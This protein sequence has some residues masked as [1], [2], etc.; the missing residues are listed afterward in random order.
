M[1]AFQGKA[2]VKKN[3]KGGAAM[4][5]T[6]PLK[7][8]SGA[9]FNELFQRAVS[10]L[11]VDKKARD[12]GVKNQPP[13]DQ[14][15]PD[16]NERE[17]VGYFTQR[18]REQRNQCEAALSKHALDR[19]A[20]TSKVDVSQTRSSL[21]SIYNAIEPDLAQKEQIHKPILEQAKRLEETSLRY[22]RHFQQEH[23]LQ[24][25][26]PDPYPDPVWHFSLVAAFAVVEWIALSIFYAEGSDFGLLG[27]II[28]AMGLSLI[29]IGLAVFAGALLRY[30]NHKSL[31]RKILALI[32]VSILILLFL[33]ATGFAAH[34]R[35]AVHDL[36]SDN[37]QQP[38]SQ[39]VPNPSAITIPLKENSDQWRASKLAYEKFQEQGFMFHDAFS[40][41]LIILA[42]LFGIIACWKGYGIDD[43]Y[44]GYGPI[45]RRFE[46]HRAAYQ[47]Q[48]KSYTDIVDGIFLKA[49]ADQQSLLQNVRR[50]IQYFQDLS[51]KSETATSEYAKFAQQVAQACNDVIF[52]YRERNRHVAT[53]AP[54]NYFALHVHLDPTLLKAPDALKESERRLQIEYANAIREF[55]EL[56]EK[57]DAKRQELRKKSINGLA[58][59]FDQIERD[60][61]AKLARE[62]QLAL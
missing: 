37:Q 49:G 47:H 22:L 56:V 5:S 53:G 13:S 7:N 16:A 52:R 41:F 12:A 38:T 62:T 39:S 3:I 8:G 28:I 15:D 11:D 4:A 31:G 36:A 42:I 51:S 40:W 20:I 18:L 50:D 58:E 2:Y 19:T 61:K 26:E 44:P 14:T 21:S 17:I 43:R 46:E 32:G 25:R 27:G 24:N 54:P 48:K 1:S 10:D 33:L 59:F 30:V 34:Y 35:T 23:S 29:N 55:T 60:I 6:Q 45:T 9:S 57:D